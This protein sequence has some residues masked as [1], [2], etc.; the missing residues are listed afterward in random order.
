M[1]VVV[2]DFPSGWLTASKL[3][4]DDSRIKPAL[5]AAA[6]RFRPVDFLLF[7]PAHEPPPSDS[8][9]NCRYDDSWNPRGS[10]ICKKCGRPLNMRSKYDVCLDAWVATHTGDRY[11]IP[12]RLPSR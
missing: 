11:G 12:L 9:D 2:R 7:D 1:A 8:P 5:R 4:L 10:K 3:G 6:A